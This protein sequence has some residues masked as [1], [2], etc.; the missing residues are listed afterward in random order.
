MSLVEELLA[1]WLVQ[2]IQGVEPRIVTLEEPIRAIGLV[3]ETDQGRARRDV[4]RMG[5]SYLAIQQRVEIPNRREPWGVLA[6][7]QDLDR[8]AATFTYMVG[9][10]VT[11]LERVPEGLRGFE[12]PAG[13]YAVFPVRARN[14]L[15][16]GLAVSQARKYAYETWLPKSSYRKADGGIDDFEYHD[17]RCARRPNPEID[18]YVAVTKW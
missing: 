10:V 17:A 18:L 2:D 15:G 16:W 7:R 5:R 3:M 14:R 12:A 8:T 4:A 13:T 6:I 9:D 11:S 1:R